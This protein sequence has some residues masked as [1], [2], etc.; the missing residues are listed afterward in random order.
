MVSDSSPLLTTCVLWICLCV[1]PQSHT[2]TNSSPSTFSSTT[3][4]CSRHVLVGYA[5]SHELS[6]R[7]PPRARL[8][9][10]AHKIP[11]TQL[12]PSTKAY[13]PSN[14]SHPLFAYTHP[15]QRHKRRTMFVRH[16]GMNDHLALCAIS[17]SLGFRAVLCSLALL[18]WD[19]TLG[20]SLFRL[21]R[22]PPSAF[23]LPP[24]ASATRRR[25]T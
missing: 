8:H 5:L 15:I 19:R 17:L 22:L 20:L 9:P 10:I 14:T 18:V 1:L 12:P 3:A 13:P 25:S 2:C 7:V 21:R 23:R 16:H 24:S 11:N 6:L 4:L